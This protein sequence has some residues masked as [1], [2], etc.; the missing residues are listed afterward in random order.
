MTDGSGDAS[1]SSSTSVSSARNAGSPVGDP[2]LTNRTT[3]A[4]LDHL[5]GVEQGTTEFGGERPSHRRLAHA[6]HADEDE[7]A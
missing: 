7:M 3:R 4:L 5:V 2:D 6:H 1:A